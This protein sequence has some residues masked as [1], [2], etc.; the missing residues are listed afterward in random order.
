MK[1]RAPGGVLAKMMGERCQ[2]NVL[3]CGGLTEMSG[4][5]P[6]QSFNSHLQQNFAH[7]PGTWRTLNLTGLRSTHTL[8]IGAGS[9]RKSVHVAVTIPKP[10]VNRS[11]EGC[12][13]A[14]GGVQSGLFEMQDSASSFGGHEG[15]NSCI[16]GVH[17]GNFGHVP[18]EAGDIESK[19]TIFDASIL[20]D[21]NPQTC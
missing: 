19:W 18:G 7:V 16:G 1:T 8:V 11:G 5:I 21:G 17:R 20:K 10:V 2:F 6:C 12:Y 14:E 4:S 9:V 15:K 3:C 13:Q